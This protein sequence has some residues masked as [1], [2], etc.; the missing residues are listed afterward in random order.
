LLKR[1]ALILGKTLKMGRGDKRTKKGKIARKS[2]GNAR[3]KRPVKSAE[4]SSKK[5]S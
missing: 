2:F 3:R 5:A 1:K 4:T